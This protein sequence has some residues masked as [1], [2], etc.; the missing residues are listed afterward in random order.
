MLV[1]DNEIWSCC[2]RFVYKAGTEVTHDIGF[3]SW[4]KLNHTTLS[5]KRKKTSGLTGLEL[6][7]AHKSFTD[8][9]SSLKVVTATNE[10]ITSEDPQENLIIFDPD[11]E[12]TLSKLLQMMRSKLNGPQVCQTPLSSNGCGFS[13]VSSLPFSGM[14]DDDLLKL[15]I[16]DGGSLKL[17]RNHKD[18][19]AVTV[20]LWS[21][22]GLYH[23]LCVLQKLIP[24]AVNLCEIQ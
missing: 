14:T 17:K 9:Q 16:K 8:I 19:L 1:E 3:L 23:H 7:M 13:Y 20:K 22:D 15:N 10:D 4:S 5:R 21:S 12:E 6:R 18:K 11:F 24:R 2:L